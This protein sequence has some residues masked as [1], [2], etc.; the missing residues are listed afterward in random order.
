MSKIIA[1]VMPLVRQIC[2]RKKCE[3]TVSEHGQNV[4][5][6]FQNGFSHELPEQS[7]IAALFALSSLVK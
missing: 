6:R 3:A 1:A 4:K 5:V 7:P 2:D